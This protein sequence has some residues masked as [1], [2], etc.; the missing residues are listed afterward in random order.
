MNKRI[1]ICIGIIWC[2]LSLTSVSAQVS[3]NT[4]T[5]I[6]SS[7]Q[8]LLRE[9]HGS[10]LYDN[11]IWII[12]GT[13]L[14]PGKENKGRND[15]WYS[16]DGINWTEATQSAAF[17]PRI[18]HTTLVF[19]N[20]MWVIG[21]SRST[22]PLNDVWYSSD[23]I[24]W[25]SATDTA[26][27]SPRER[28]SSVVYNN[29]MWVIGGYDG[30]YKN[31]TW[32]SSDGVTWIMAT[33]SADF[34]ARNAHTSLVFDERMWII[35]G[36][37]NCGDIVESKND[38]WSS[39]DGETWIQETP[40][41]DFPQR[42]YHTSVVYGGKMWVIGG[43]DDVFAYPGGGLNDIWN[44]A[45]GRKWN[46][47]VPE[48]SFSPRA[49]HTSVVFDNKILVIAGWDNGYRAD[50]WTYTSESD[51]KKFLMG[52]SPYETIH[53]DQTPASEELFPFMGI[54]GMMLAIISV[55]LTHRKR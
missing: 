55:R 39:S 4:H 9:A 28:H 51:T 30:Q 40:S 44:S 33:E 1:L 12:G 22:V 34:P 18:G 24:T 32:Y 17:P 50:V 21:G 3:G 35:G 54:F 16:S 37:Y 7:P 49:G 20:R 43:R 26:S 19:N 2:L 41:A 29:K 46:R 31:D 36:F 42:D 13:A 48:T 15:V 47:V 10:V 11:R 6:D 52:P 23:G 27:F 38:V 25:T 53:P 8:V 45:D 5:L 14:D